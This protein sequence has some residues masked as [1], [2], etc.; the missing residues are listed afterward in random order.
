MRGGKSSG[1]AQECARHITLKEK[2]AI[3]G[4]HELALSGSVVVSACIVGMFPAEFR[5]EQHSAS[6][7]V[8]PSQ[9]ML[10]VSSLKSRAL[11][12]NIVEELVADAEIILGTQLVLD[13]IND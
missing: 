3:A 4:K 11:A 9:Q 1:I 5:A 10:A 12:H 8:A 6:H 7:P 2:D 13:I